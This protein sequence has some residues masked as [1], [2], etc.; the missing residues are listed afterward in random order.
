MR[1]RTVV[2][3]ISL[4]IACRTDLPTPP[5]SVSLD[6]SPS[7][8]SSVSGYEVIDL[9]NLGGDYVTP[10]AISDSGQIAGWSTTMTGETHAFYWERGTMYDVGPLEGPLLGQVVND[11]GQVAGRGA[12]GAPPT[13]FAW[14]SATPSPVR[15]GIVRRPSEDYDSGEALAISDSGIVLATIERY[16]RSE[17]VLW[18]GDTLLSLGHLNWRLITTASAMNHRGQVVGSSVA[19]ESPSGGQYFHPFLWENGQMQD[20][21]VLGRP[22]CTPG[23]YCSPA[24]GW[25]RDINDR[26]EVVG[27]SVDSNDVSRAFLWKDGVMR[28]LG[29]FPGARTEALAINQN[30]QIMGRYSF[31]RGFFY[32]AGATQDLGTLG[33]N[34]T[35][36]V[37]MNDSAEIVGS[38]TTASGVNQA[39]V[40]RNGVMTNLG[41]LLDG[42][43]SS[44]AT[45]INSRGDIIGV[46]EVQ[47]QPRR[48]ILWRKMP[49]P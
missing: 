9:G 21:G 36:V 15:A 18:M 35:L 12:F 20:L 2:L 17:A 38:S 5:P 25:A 11:R 41:L 42:A 46:S 23:S 3:A 47:H 32:D 4:C 37:A 40:W 1:R 29:A 44:R 13:L 10:T 43:E 30:G 16:G 6:A 26:G 24:Q 22:V 33:G 48:A 27:M 8:D 14:E 39:F 34:T 45:G 31:S 19:Y 7:N 49:G 28:D